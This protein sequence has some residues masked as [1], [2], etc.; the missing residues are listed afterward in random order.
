M[1]LLVDRARAADLE[2]WREA[3]F[4][5]QPINRTEGRAVLHTALRNRDPNRPV[6]VG[7]RDVMPD[8]RA[9]LDQMRR[10]SDAVRSG[11]WTGHT[12]RRDHRRGQYRHRRLGPRPR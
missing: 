4:E 9:V 6:R 1:A 7:G 2:G 8:V 3:M 10:F 12:G 5:G 11:A